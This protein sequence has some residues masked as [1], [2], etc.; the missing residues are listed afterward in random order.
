MVLL[1]TK[2]ERGR[3]PGRMSPVKRRTRTFLWA[4]DMGLADCRIAE[5][6]DAKK[7]SGE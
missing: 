3:Y 4:E 6:R 7:L 2:V 5:V 1:R